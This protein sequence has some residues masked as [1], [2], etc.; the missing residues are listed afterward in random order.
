MD[1]DERRFGYLKTFSE[2]ELKTITKEC[3]Y[4]IEK[5]NAAR[6]E[7]IQGEELT[8]LEVDYNH[9]MSKIRYLAKVGLYKEEEP[10]KKL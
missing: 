7:K 10:K 2:E 1:F 5:Y 8:E 4:D 6:D 9:S 3:L